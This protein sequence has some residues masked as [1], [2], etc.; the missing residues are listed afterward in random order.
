MSLAKKEIPN[1]AGIKFTSGDLEKGVACLRHGQVFLGA[2]TILS[3]ALALG[4]ESAIM[5]TLNICPEL[6]L[7][8][9]EAMAEGKLADA[10]ATQNK[11]NEKVAEILALS[12]K[13]IFSYYYDN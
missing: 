1:F 8:I 10:L 11:L 2:D 12:M 9:V 3:G 5:T 4:F 6:S 7:Q 13:N